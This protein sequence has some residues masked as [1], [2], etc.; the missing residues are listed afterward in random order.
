MANEAV[1]I[2]L[3]NNNPVRLTVANETGIEK[4]ALLKLTDP[5]TASATSGAGDVFAGIAA[6]EKVASDGATSLALHVPGQ[7]NIF[8][9]YCPGGA[10]T[11]GQYVVTS[12]ANMIKAAS[13][14]DF[15]AGKVIGKALETCASGTPETIAVLV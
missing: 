14:A 4:G 15:E 6:A 7:G 10:I 13:D 2:E 9:L 8:D 12:G 3:N 11:A 5:R 1:I